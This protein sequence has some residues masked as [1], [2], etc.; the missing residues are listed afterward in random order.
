M[1]L[2]A[3]G[4]RWAGPRALVGEA[5]GIGRCGDGRGGGSVQA[6][7]FTLSVRVGAPQVFWTCIVLLEAAYAGAIAFGCTSPV[8]RAHYAVLSGSCPAVQ[9]LCARAQGWWVYQRS[10]I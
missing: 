10:C 3:P 5:D 7:I 4:H 2:H 6:G 8:R 9:G 1:V